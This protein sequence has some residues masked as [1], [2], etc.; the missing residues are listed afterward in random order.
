MSTI[1]MGPP[2]PFVLSIGP[3]ETWEVVVSGRCVVC[4]CVVE[5]AEAHDER[6]DHHLGDGR[7]CHHYYS[8]TGP[9]GAYH[10]ASGELGATCGDHSLDE[11]V[12]ALRLLGL[13]HRKE[14]R[15]L[16]RPTLPPTR[17]KN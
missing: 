16:T 12:A 10:L 9:D 2:E 1:D 15:C 3:P 17:P 6:D 8:L 4:G 7:V 13:P 14:H 5:V 11:A